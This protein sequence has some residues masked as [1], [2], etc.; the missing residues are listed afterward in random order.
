MDIYIPPL[1]A[2]VKSYVVN[3][4]AWLPEG[5]TKTVTF[6]GDPGATFTLN[7]DIDGINVNESLALEDSGS[8]SYQLSANA[9]SSGLTRVYTYTLSGNIE[10]PFAQD[11]P[12][13]INQPSS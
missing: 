13:V 10:S 8:L 11:N 3:T 12:F 6:Y 1:T 9:N 4:K 5:G 7:I 2:V